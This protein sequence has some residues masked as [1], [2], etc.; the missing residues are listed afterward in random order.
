MHFA[1]AKEAFYALED[2]LQ[3][4][5]I[6]EDQF[7][8]RVAE[9]E[10][11][12][13]EGRR[14]RISARGGRWLLHD[15]RSWVPAD[16]D[17][18]AD[19]VLAATVSLPLEPEAIPHTPPPER[20]RRRRALA[21]ATAAGA[22]TAGGATAADTAEITT[23][24]ETVVVPAAVL[25]TRGRRR[26]RPRPVASTAVSEVVTPAPRVRR[27]ALPR[28]G[29]VM[30]TL[31]VLACLVAGGVSAWVLVLR[32]L[33]EGTPSPA[34]PTEVALIQTYT[35][36]AATA[37]YTPTA[38]PTPSRTP[39][40]SNTPQPTATD[41]PPTPTAAGEEATTP[42]V[43]EQG[44]TVQAG[45][46][47]QEIAVRFG[48]S[49]DELAAANGITNMALVRPGQVLT[50]PPGGSAPVSEATSTPT[51]TPIAVS[52]SAQTSTPAT[53]GTR[54]T[55]L[56]TV[57]SETE[58]PTPS[59]TPTATKSPAT[60]TPTRTPTPSGP[61]ATPQP[62]NT[63]A[64][65]VAPTARPS[66]LSGKIAFTV[67][68]KFENEYDLYVSRIDGQGRNLLGTGF[69]QPQFRRD[70]AALAVNGEAPSFDH[71]VKMN[72]SGGE[73]IEVSN[74][75][76]DAYP[77]WSPDGSIVVYSTLS[78]GDGVSRLGIVNDMFGK[79]QDWIRT[80]QTEVRGEYPYWMED[81][82]VVYHG[83]DFL[84]DQGACGLF[85]VGAGGGNYQKI[86]GNG[87]DTAPAGHGQKVAFMSARDGNWEVYRVNMDGSG[88]QRLTN[89]ASQ[90]GLPTWSPD[91]K[92]IAFVS[93]RGGA[94]AI[95]VMN[96]DG[97]NQVKLF[98]LGGAYGAGDHD[99][100]TERISW[101]P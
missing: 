81:G 84:V 53:P 46:T 76:E 66:A 12:D 18:Q 10:V 78:W 69:R 48:I 29:A 89:S 43:D 74:Y 55:A 50:I 32:D 99:W 85:W 63:P 60:S 44:Y 80:A 65:T 6:S 13:P 37:T 31:L 15:G 100:T 98:D 41:V 90:D 68:N 64:P 70:G 25:G 35:P 7:L 59:A 45:E 16:P 49:V 52:T 34:A 73:K 95:W 27:P 93:N 101:A 92:S 47:L 75:S 40:P 28:I 26:A 11:T 83:C 3:R 23:A 97:G 79:Q 94:W 36:R 38:T 57:T 67:W 56:A 24:A 20:P 42:A 86:T 1:E 14:W 21:A 58:T 39:V 9:L 19:D 77:T 88:L 17:L 61:T 72:A 2:R 5:E 87:T 51:W 54:A 8:D 91:G 4:G 30:T 22:A 96:A 62:T 33:G 71:L 82:R